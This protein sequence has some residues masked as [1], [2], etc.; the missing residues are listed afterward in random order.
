[1]YPCLVVIPGEFFFRVLGEELVEADDLWAVFGSVGF[2]RPRR[3]AG[4]SGE[5]G[6]EVIAGD[7]GPGP[8]VAAF[9]LREAFDAVGHVGHEHRPLR[10]G[11]GTAAAER[12]ESE[13][14][15][16]VYRRF[17][18]DLHFAGRGEALFIN[19]HRGSSR[20]FKIEFCETAREGGRTVTPLIRT[21][22][23]GGGVRRTRAVGVDTSTIAAAAG[24]EVVSFL[25]SFGRMFADENNVARGTSEMRF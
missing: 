21:R 5:A 24:V 16:Y 19:V 11:G 6:E 13:I 25:T 3:D 10:P 2:T 17:R 15:T 18:L 8:S 7:L 9:G 22:F 20:N 23:G 14:F 1:M 4:A 12:S